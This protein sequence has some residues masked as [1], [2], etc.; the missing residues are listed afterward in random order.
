M[1][2]ASATRDIEGRAAEARTVVSIIISLTAVVAASK[3]VM[4]ALIIS[5]L[6]SCCQYRFV[7]KGS[8]R[9][10]I[11]CRGAYWYDNV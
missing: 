2:W 3:T 9:R 10:E 8:K 6:W 4:Y 1:K 11:G 7:E 5:G